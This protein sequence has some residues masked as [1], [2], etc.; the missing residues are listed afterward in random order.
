MGETLGMGSFAG[1][2]MWF[3]AE[4]FG[5]DISIGYARKMKNLVTF[6]YMN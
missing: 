3:F 1:G 4:I 6:C 5:L 2:M